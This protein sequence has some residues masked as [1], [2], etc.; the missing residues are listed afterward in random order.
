MINNVLFYNSTIDIDIYFHS[1]MLIEREYFNKRYV[2]LIK[3]TG[4]FPGVG[5]FN[6]VK[7][8]VS[9]VLITFFSV[10]WY[11]VYRVPSQLNSE[12]VCGKLA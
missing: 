1:N 7:S 3:H 11:I 8:D 10:L 6:D 9:V 4:N 2:N 12:W 5:Q